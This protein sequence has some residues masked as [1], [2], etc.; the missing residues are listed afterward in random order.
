MLLGNPASQGHMMGRLFGGGR[1]RIKVW[2][3]R[4]RVLPTPEVLFKNH[5]LGHR[6]DP[7][8]QQQPRRDWLTLKPQGTGRLL[9]GGRG[10]GRK[11]VTHMSSAWALCM[12]SAECACTGEAGTEA[13]LWL[14]VA[15]LGLNPDAALTAGHLRHM[16]C[17]RRCQSPA[18]R[19]QWGSVLAVPP[20]PCMPGRESG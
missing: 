12:A 2:Q 5:L 16:V 3:W 15:H 14:L 18:S 20:L 4:G 13:R 19:V 7:R 1:S 9:W 6:A 11:R 17:E 8:S 10:R